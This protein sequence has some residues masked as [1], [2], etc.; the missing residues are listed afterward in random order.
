MFK[1][2]GST[3][4]VNKKVNANH[5]PP[6]QKRKHV[7][8]DVGIGGMPKDMSQGRIFPVEGNEKTDN[9]ANANRQCN[10]TSFKLVT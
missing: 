3:I 9:H 2:Q 5:D 1:N 10:N 4:Q 7:T 8:S 6:I